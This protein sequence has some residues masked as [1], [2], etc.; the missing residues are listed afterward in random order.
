MKRLII[1]AILLL[2]GCASIKA[3]LPSGWDA[4]QSKIATDMQQTARQLDCTAPDAALNKLTDEIQWFD[5]YAKSKGTA[6]VA[7]VTISLQAVVT[8]FQDRRKKESVS[9]FYCELKKKI[10]IQDADIIARTVQGR[11]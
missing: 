2:S 11:F 3:Y 7:P 5:L 9:P 6:D 1:F 10:M 4:N 8:E